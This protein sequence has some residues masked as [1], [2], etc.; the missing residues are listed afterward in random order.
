MISFPVRKRSNVDNAPATQRTALQ[1]TLAKPILVKVEAHAREGCFLPASAPEATTFAS[2][3]K[4]VTSAPQKAGKRTQEAD[5]GKENNMKHKWVQ[6]WDNRMKERAA[7]LRRDLAAARKQ[8]RRVFDSQFLLTKDLCE[9]PA[10]LAELAALRL[11]SVTLSRRLRDTEEELGE[12]MSLAREA[13]LSW[14]EE[15]EEVAGKDTVL[16]PHAPLA[17]PAC[18]I[19]IRDRTSHL[20]QEDFRTVNNHQPPKVNYLEPF[21]RFFLTLPSVGT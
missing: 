16:V 12:K 9:Q 11:V 18:L 10:L 4:A 15:E 1:P 14:E 8:A 19:S 7:D 6:C 5:V 13:K 2:V 20:R 3:L 17:P 21:R